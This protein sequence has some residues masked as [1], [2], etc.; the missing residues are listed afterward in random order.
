MLEL[1]GGDK[2]D[3]DMDGIDGV[4]EIEYGLS[5]WTGKMAC[6]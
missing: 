1:C 4:D 2:D 5:N 3:L 6:C